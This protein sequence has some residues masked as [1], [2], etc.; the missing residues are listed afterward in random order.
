MP[1]AAFLRGSQHPGPNC[2]D[3]SPLSLFYLDIATSCN[4]ICK[5]S[6]AQKATIFMQRDDATGAKTKQP[7]HDDNYCR[8]SSHTRQEIVEDM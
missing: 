2:Y 6:D 4:Y 1:E 3:S 8:R 5:A 7:E